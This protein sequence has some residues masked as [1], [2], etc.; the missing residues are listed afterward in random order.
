MLMMAQSG[1]MITLVI[2]GVAMSGISLYFHCD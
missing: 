2:F 1:S